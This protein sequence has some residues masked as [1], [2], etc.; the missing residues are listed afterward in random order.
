MTGFCTVTLVET[1]LD[2]A[3]AT[4]PGGDAAVATAAAG[5]AG[6]AGGEAAGDPAAPVVPE[7]LL[8]AFAVSGVLCVVLM[9]YSM[10]VSVLL[11]IFAVSRGNQPRTKAQRLAGAAGGG[12]GAASTRGGGGGPSKADIQRSFRRH[13]RTSMHVFCVGALCFLANIVLFAWVKFAP[14]P[15]IKW[16][17]TGTVCAAAPLFVQ[18][19]YFWLRVL[20]KS[21]R[22]DRTTRG[23]VGGGGGGGGAAVRSLADALAHAE[24]KAATP[25]GDAAV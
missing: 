4:G 22:D 16:A 3:A 8:I 23:P 15:S 24:E 17:I 21:G 12:A 6:A 25:T 13:G 18:V 19:L 10:I 11:M 7:A 14:W 20:G 9:L 5:A 2:F 1:S